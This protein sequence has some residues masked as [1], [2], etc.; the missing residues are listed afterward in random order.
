MSEQKQVPVSAFQ[1]E[2]Q[3]SQAFE[4]ED[5]LRTRCRQA[6]CVATLITMAGTG[7]LCIETEE[8][9][10]IGLLLSNIIT[11]LKAAIDAQIEL[12]TEA[13]DANR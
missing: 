10:N 9:A 13:R 8:L 12:R 6:Q 2:F 11:D 3:L 4:I 1:R 7:E 5:A